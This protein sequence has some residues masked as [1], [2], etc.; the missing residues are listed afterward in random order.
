MSVDSPDRSSRAL[1]VGDEVEI[2]RLCIEW[3]WMIDHERAD[4]VHELFS[5][6][7]TLELSGGVM[8]GLDE[9]RAWGAKRVLAERTSRHLMANHRFSLVGDDEAE[10]TTLVWSVMDQG[11]ANE[12][13]A[14]AGPSVVIGEY[15]DQFER[16]DGQWRIQSRRF[17]VIFRGKFQYV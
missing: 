2:T 8:N 14:E 5:S 13:A 3:A 15:H 1:D 11:L 10:G 7:A 9:I 12:T 17:I 16:V 4:H 6:D